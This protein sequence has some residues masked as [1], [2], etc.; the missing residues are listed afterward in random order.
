MSVTI[1]L[2]AKDYSVLNGEVKVTGYAVW[3]YTNLWSPTHPKCWKFSKIEYG[4]G[5]FHRCIIFEKEED[6]VAFRLR[7]GV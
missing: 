2:P 1:K 3:C 4:H 5:G 7:F 6:A